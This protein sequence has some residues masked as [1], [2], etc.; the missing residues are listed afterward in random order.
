MSQGEKGRER[1]REGERGRER[2]KELEKERKKEGQR[3]GFNFLE[4]KPEKNLLLLNQG[5]HDS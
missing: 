1:E 3:V 4:G 2:E 5:E